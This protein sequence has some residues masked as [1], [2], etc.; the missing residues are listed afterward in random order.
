[1]SL[2]VSNP[3]RQQ[4]EFH[5]RT[6]ITKDT[7]GP[8]VVVIPSGGQV[9]IGHGWTREQMAY[10]IQQIELG[11]G[12]DAALA[13]GKMGKFTGLLYR[14]SNPV[15]EDEIVTANKSVEQDAMERSVAQAT[16]SAVAFDRIANKNQGRQ[17]GRLAK[18]TTVEIVQELEPH[19]HRTGD[20]V[21]FS[22]TVDPDGRSDVR[23]PGL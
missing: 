21:E 3:S 14:V 17:K 1:M 15:D 19:A 12:G 11:G 22:L 4:V 8:S 16:R 2:Y 18:S 23:M 13:H 20:E 7:S 10:V 9:E 6:A 5:Y